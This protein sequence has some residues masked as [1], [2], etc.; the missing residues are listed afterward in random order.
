MPLFQSG[1]PPAVADERPMLDAWLDLHRDILLL[2][3][4]HI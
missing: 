1:E 3:L 2:S 4:I